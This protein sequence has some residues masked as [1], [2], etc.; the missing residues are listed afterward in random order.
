MIHVLDQLTKLA[1]A[2]KKLS[3]VNG[4]ADLYEASFDLVKEI[5][6]NETSAILLKD[7]KDKI[8]TIAAARGYD[9]EIVRQF[10]AAPGQGITGHVLVSGEPQLVTEAV[11]DPRYIR[12]VSEATSEMSVPLRAGNEI[13]G[14]LDMESKEA[15]FT[16][17]DLALFTTF[18]EQVAIA[19]QNLRLQAN[20]EE[21]ARKLVTIA[22]AG[23]FMT[24][25]SNLDDL[26][27]RIL[28]STKDA[29]QLDTCAIQLWDENQENLV[30]Q[31]AQGYDRDVIGL[32]VPRGTGVTGKAASENRP[33]II[34]DVQEVNDY[35]VGLHECRSEMAVPL[36]FRDEVIGVLNAEHRDPN[37]F[38]ETDLLHATIFADQTAGAIGNAGIRADLERSTR[39]VNQLTSRID[40][41]A[42]TAAKVNGITDLDILLDEILAMALQV[43]QFERIAVL[44]P[45]P[46][47]LHLKVHRA[48]GYKEGTIGRRVPV[49]SSI[50]GEAYRSGQSVLVSD[51]RG[52]PRYIEGCPDG[53]SEIAAPLNVADEVVGVLDAESIGDNVMTE[54]DLKV[55]DM[56]AAQVATAVRNARQRADMDERN[57]RLTLIHRAACSLNAV[58]DP[59]KMLLTILR[60]AQKALGLEMV[61][62][63]TPERDGKHLT[64]R[65][66]INHGDVEGLKV[67][68]GEGFTGKMFVSGKAGIIDDV[69]KNKDY[70]DGGTAGAL[71]E[72]AAPLSLNG[73]IIGILDTESMEAHAFSQA[74][75]ELFRIFGSQVATALHNAQMVY[76]LEDRARKL[77]LIHRAACSLNTVDDPEDMLG[78]ILT[79]ARKAIGLEMV[80]ILTPESDGKHL[81]VR[82][83]INHGDV[84]GLR[85]PI[86]EGFT[87]K[88][89]VDGKANIIQ[90]TSKHEDYISGG[91]AGALSEMAAPLSLE[92]ETIGI[93]DAE[94]MEANAFTKADLDMLRVFA[95]QVATALKNVRLITQL[96]SRSTRLNL[97]NQASNALNSIHQI[98]ELVEKILR[99]AKEALDLDRCALLLLDPES[100]ELKVDASIGYGDI[101]GMRIPLGK[102]ITGMTAVSGEPTLVHDTTKD[103]R[104]VNGKSDGRSEMA[105]PL[106]VHGE[107]IGVLDTESPTPNAFDE[108]DLKLFNAFA[109]QAAVAIHNARLF[110][111][112]ETANLKLSDNV[113]EMA[114][115]NKE[116]ET[117]SAE[118]ASANENLASQLKNLTAV[119]EAGKTITSSLDLDTTLET[120]L[121]M[122]STIVGSTAGAI[123]LIDDETK[124]L[125]T[126]A[127]SGAISEITGSWSIFDMPLKI[128]DK[129]IGVFELVR[130]AKDN[131]RD[132]DRQMLETMASQAAIA[133]E[134]ARL[135][136]DT[137]RIYYETLK[138]LAGALEA[139]DD[140]TR[141]HSERVATLSKNIA[142]TIDLPEQ[143]RLTIYN[144]ALLHDI[145]KIGIR[146]EVLL[147]PR[148]LTDEEMAVIQKHP[149]F[150]N[151]ILAPLKFLGE[152]REYVRHHHERWDGTGYPDKRKS[153]DIPLA[154]RIIAVADTYDAMT[155]DR[156][157]RNQL[158][159]ETAVSEIQKAAGTQFDPEVVKAFL[160]VIPT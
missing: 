37:R 9:E 80:A 149:S 136:E 43:L 156:P 104:Y 148:R 26:L 121:D 75:L 72:M 15:R 135:F 10:R 120:I 139:R 3:N 31:A 158:S 99:L 138:S 65:K 114:R 20:L 8:L 36:V 16:T 101:D 42:A 63:L 67:P 137:Q 128:G 112:L 109:A 51:V 86:G 68:I 122:T 98:D 119:H 106:R 147:A 11:N 78:N 73:G 55:L 91:T 7:P 144:A 49:D 141:G 133:I 96:R 35:I 59:E 58:D 151:M 107:V 89:F 102:G 53:R 146:D 95:S 17:A 66:A 92:G 4:F 84:E 52:D 150:G 13:I 74:D 27:E 34:P 103:D 38:D 71:S 143:E 125:R 93:L 39:E 6:D 140:Y 90:D 110:K 54:S 97:L 14:V 45:E 159:K 5:F 83:A 160:K 123:K 116:L 29:L 50:T 79:L 19:I 76:D 47:N 124:E 62:I 2:G 145:G 117:Y 1:E 153:N 115:L 69:T 94:A 113:N 24:S 61:A 155:S 64:V 40:L 25:V 57:R 87:G 23:Q 60:L 118:I 105:S 28:I 44:L 30:V 131:I 81:T 129:T 152:I 82:K 132:E 56:L 46:S 126:R 18:G 32:K 111:G 127:E 41:L 108:E 100:K 88:M 21:R 48:H 85:I 142:E 157:Y 134:N 130:G 12:G 77:T 70:I 154:S 33:S 22:K